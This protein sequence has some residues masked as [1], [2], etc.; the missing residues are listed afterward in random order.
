MGTFQEMVIADPTP[1]PT[2][3]DP[4]AEPTTKPTSWPTKLPTNI[5]IPTKVPTA[6]PT[7]PSPFSDAALKGTEIVA[8]LVFSVV[9][10]AALV[11]MIYCMLKAP[12]SKQQPI[13]KSQIDD[14]DPPADPVK[15]MQ[16]EDQLEASVADV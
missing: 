12:R 14:Q 6:E 13:S 3:P 5:N 10:F 7:L 16:L 2:G 8:I 9:G 4:T 1:S 15:Q 11:A